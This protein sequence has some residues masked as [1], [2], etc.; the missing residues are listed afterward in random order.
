MT[1]RFEVADMSDRQ[2]L[3]ELLKGQRDQNGA[4]AAIKSDFYGDEARKI[5]G[6]KP[7][8][9]ENTLTID[10]FRTTVRTV[11]W[12]VGFFGLGNIAVWWKI[13]AG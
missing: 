8:V 6:V 13:L 10:R 11:G 5:I 7:Q 1:G 3:L 12:L 9:A 4:I 2:I